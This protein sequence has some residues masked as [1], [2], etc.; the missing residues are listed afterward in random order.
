MDDSYAKLVFRRVER[1]KGDGWETI[2]FDLLKKG[3]LF[4]LYD[5]V[6]EGQWENGKEVYIAK[7]DAE[8]YYFVW[9]H[10]DPFDNYY[11]IEADY[12]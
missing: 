7:S 12:A 4:K 11:M 2:T 6:G 3:D 10:H 1:K 8:P 5:P 9:S